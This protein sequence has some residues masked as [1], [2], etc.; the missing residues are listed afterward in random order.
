MILSPT[1]GL[2]L[3]LSCCC[4]S[5]A[6]IELSEQY[7]NDIKLDQAA[8]QADYNYDH[9]G[10]D[11][12]G[13]C[14]T[15]KRQSPI[16]L[17]RFDTVPGKVPRL[18][19]LNYDSDLQTPL[20]LMNNGHTANLVIPPTRNGQRPIVTGG[21]LPGS[22]EAQSMHFHWGSENSSGTE[23]II[24]DLRDIAQVEVHIVHKNIRYKTVAEAS[25]HPDGLAVLAVLIRSSR[26][27]MTS[28]NNLV[29]I[30]NRVPRI[31]RYGTNVTITG[32]LTAENLMGDIVTGQF[33]TYNGSLTTP[34]CAEAVTWVVFPQIV[35]IY[36]RIVERLYNL[37]DSR[38]KPLI[39]NYRSIQDTNGRPVYY[40][41]L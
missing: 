28:S 30:F 27:P 20:V 1:L 26:S 32:K 34:D 35:N 12:D 13:L 7:L 41:N 16:V 19:F 18:R 33:F 37:R 31:V 21:L 9:Q 4:C 11:W 40:R 8:D 10:D 24:L 25:M 36:Y 29:K 6:L 14:Q 5:N 39:N 17:N 38:S 23:H 3:V 22:F 2:L 15:G